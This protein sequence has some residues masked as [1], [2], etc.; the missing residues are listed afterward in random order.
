MKPKILVVDDEWSMR[1]LLKNTLESFGFEPVLAATAQEFEKHVFSFRP[2]AIILDIVLD[3]LDGT[4]V[5]D[6]LLKKGMDETIPVVFLS[7]LACDVT[8]KMPEKNRRYSLVGKPFNPA[9]LGE[10]LHQII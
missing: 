6:C 2:D 3:D 5:Y 1:E 4:V 7:A 10:R 8:S 9:E